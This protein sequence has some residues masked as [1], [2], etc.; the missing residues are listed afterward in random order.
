[1]GTF[2]PLSHNLLL[3]IRLSANL[4]LSV[5]SSISGVTLVLF[6]IFMQILSLMELN[7][8]TFERGQSASEVTA[9][10]SC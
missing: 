5:D 6:N 2:N 3:I 4:C 8:L 9:H 1:M 7:Y 10:A